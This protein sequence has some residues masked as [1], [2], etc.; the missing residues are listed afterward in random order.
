MEVTSLS[1]DV[2]IESLLDDI[3]NSTSLFSG[4]TAGCV[5]AARLADSNPQLSILVIEGGSDNYNLPTIIHPAL[6]QSNFAPGATT[7]L[8]MGSGE[9]QLANRAMVTPVASVLGGGSSVNGVIYARAQRSDYDSWGV[10]GW[11]SEELIPFMRRVSD[12]LIL[13]KRPT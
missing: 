10:E 8:L 2:N 11:S 4:G 7:T 12:N 6:Y 3:A 13:M 1:D 9:P 5:V